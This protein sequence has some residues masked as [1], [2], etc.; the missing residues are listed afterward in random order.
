MDLCL[1]VPFLLSCTSWGRSSRSGRRSRSRSSARW[2]ARSRSTRTSSRPVNGRRQ[3]AGRSAGGALPGRSPASLMILVL[4]STCTSKLWLVVGIVLYVIAIAYALD[5]PGRNGRTPH[6]AD[7]DAARRPAAAGPPPE[8]LAT[9]KKS[10]AGGMFLGVPD[11]G[12]R[13]PDGGQALPLIAVSDVAARL[14]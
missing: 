10:S 7:L 9:V 6:R 14:P 4:G 2:P 12:H 8:L 3:Q 13:V 1:A 5:R 11:R